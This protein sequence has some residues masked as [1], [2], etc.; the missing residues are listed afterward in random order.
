MGLDTSH[1]CWHGPYSAFNRWRIGVAAAAN[2]VLDYM[3][4][5]AGDRPGLQW[6]ET[7]VLSILLHH[8]DC[9]GDIPADNCAALAD[10][11]EGL[12]P[13]LPKVG[14]RLWRQ[15]DYWWTVDA[16]EVEWFQS[17]TRQFIA[18]LRRAAAAGEAVEFG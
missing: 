14:E 10:R 2:I 12:L 17:R 6:D 11:L 8:S 16:D 18:G 9:E 15:P 1:D 13:K 4:G 5:H 3:M 7:D